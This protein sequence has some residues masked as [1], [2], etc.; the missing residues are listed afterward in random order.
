MDGETA[1][2]TPRLI[3]IRVTVGTSP[4]ANAESSAKA[5]GVTDMEEVGD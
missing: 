3:V 5:D 1:S 4:D 2:E